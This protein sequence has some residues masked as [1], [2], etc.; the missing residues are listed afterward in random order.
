[1][2]R[3]M[4]EYLLNWQNDGLRCKF[5]LCFINYIMVI[6]LNL[7]LKVKSLLIGRKGGNAVDCLGAGF[8]LMLKSCPPWGLGHVLRW[9]HVNLLPSLTENKSYFLWWAVEGNSR[10]GS[11]GEGKRKEGGR[12]GRG[13][14]EKKMEEKEVEN[15]GNTCDLEELQVARYFIAGQ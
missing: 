15:G 5:T 7:Y 3:D 8:I 6:V 1:M 12:Q 14:R 9:F 11:F 10:A 2:L 4:M 13:W